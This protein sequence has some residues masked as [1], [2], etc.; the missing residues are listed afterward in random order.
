MCNR[1]GDCPARI[2]NGLSY[3]FL[4]LAAGNLSQSF[5]SRRYLGYPFPRLRAL[6]SS[7]Y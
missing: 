5:I 2:A 7:G 1:A 6:T 3:R 4:I